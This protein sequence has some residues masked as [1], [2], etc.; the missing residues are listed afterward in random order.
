MRSI[1]AYA[2]SV[3]ESQ[4]DKHSVRCRLQ[5]LPGDDN[6]YVPFVRLIPNPAKTGIRHLKHG[7]RKFTWQPEKC[8]V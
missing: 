3:T 7:F 5:E 2:W 4:A 1:H 6:R 8:K